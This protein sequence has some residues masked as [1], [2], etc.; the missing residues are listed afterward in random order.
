M[1]VSIAVLTVP[2]IPSGSQAKIATYTR[3][4]P[5][6]EITTAVIT[7]D[8]RIVKAYGHDGVSID[9]P[10]RDYEIGGI[11]KTFIGSICARAIGDGIMNFNEKAGDMLP[12]GQGIYNASVIDLLTH[13]SAYGSYTAEKYSSAKL[14]A[15]KNPYAGIRNSDIILAMDN[16]R[17][18]QSPPFMYSYSDFGAA[19]LGLMVASAYGTDI[20]TLLTIYAQ[21]ELELSGTYIATEDSIEN[22]WLWDRDESFIAACG[23]TSNI[24][25]M[26]SYAELYLN[27]DRPEISE[28]MRSLCEVNMDLSVGY[29]WELYENGNVLAQSGETSGYASQILIDRDSGTAVI[30]LSN[31]SNDKYGSVDD[32]AWALLNEFR[33]Q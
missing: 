9:V 25:D 31:Y 24:S 20:H 15:G 1:C 2:Q 11:T 33:V 13:T 7:R 18:L 3:N 27:P 23:L 21:K 5:H 12:L 4:K 16:F 6:A 17:L 26:I 22:G 28:A 29:F 32:I 10:N 8:G 14:R 19:I 30:V